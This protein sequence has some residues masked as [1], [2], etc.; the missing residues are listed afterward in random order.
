MTLVKNLIKK[1]PITTSPNNT[2][3]EAVNLMSIN[4]VG[5]LVITDSNNKVLGI[6]SERDIINALANNI[7]IAKARIS[8]IMKTRI[9]KIRENE[10]A[11]KASSLMLKHNIRH[12]VV[13]NDRDELIGVLSIRDLLT[14][15]NPVLR[16]VEYVKLEELDEWWFG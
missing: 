10:S 3:R 2:L 5:F 15:S 13:V 7:D 16:K 14:T 6:L 1:Q 12:L 8:K 11:V 9:I 4:G